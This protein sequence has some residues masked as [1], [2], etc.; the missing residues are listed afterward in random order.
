MTTIF[1]QCVFFLLTMKNPINGETLLA[2]AKQHGDDNLHK[3][4]SK[5]IISNEMISEK[6]AQYSEYINSVFDKLRN[7]LSKVQ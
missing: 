3:T 2:I 4:L 6:L 1:L 5:Y 7:D